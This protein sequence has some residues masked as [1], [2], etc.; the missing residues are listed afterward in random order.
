MRIDY[1]PTTPAI[2]VFRT[3][4]FNFLLAV[5]A[6]LRVPGRNCAF[7][8]P[9]EVPLF[10]RGTRFNGLW[11]GGRASIRRSSAGYDVTIDSCR[12]SLQATN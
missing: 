6:E 7:G 2:R 11:A 4:T 10:S 1:T 3:L 8:A 12:R 9:K 5:R